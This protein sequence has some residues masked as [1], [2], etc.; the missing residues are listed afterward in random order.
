MARGRGGSH[1]KER[2]SF[3]DSQTNESNNTLP[4]YAVRPG[5]RHEE[6]R[7]IS[8]LSNS[9]FGLPFVDSSQRALRDPL[10]RSPT[11]ALARDS[12]ISNVSRALV[13]VRHSSEESV[14]NPF[15]EGSRSRIGSD[16]SQLQRRIQHSDKSPGVIDSCLSREDQRQVSGGNQR[17][18]VRI[19]ECKQSKAQGASREDETPQS[20]A[21][22][23]HVDL[24]QGGNPLL[25]YSIAQHAQNTLSA[26]S[27]STTLSHGR[28]VVPPTPPQRPAQVNDDRSNEDAFTPKGR[29]GKSSSFSIGA[30]K[31]VLPASR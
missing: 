13:P 15:R 7:P 18:E 22:T 12:W 27:G 3:E 25:Q 6:A 24:L 26:S 5:R 8:E 9:S 29:L 21:T 23:A 19:S 14:G 10:D 11:D 30:A 4:L 28:L 31:A 20:R 1:T 17:S 16:A 2:S